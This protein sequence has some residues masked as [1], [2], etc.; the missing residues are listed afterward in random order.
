MVY[1]HTSGHNVHFV[2]QIAEDGHARVYA[3]V[4][5]ACFRFYLISIYIEE[6]VMLE[7]S[8]VDRSIL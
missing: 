5:H 1:I 4:L 6:E 7:S 2:L 8:E 3:H